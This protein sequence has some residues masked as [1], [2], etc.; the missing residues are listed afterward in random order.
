MVIKVGGSTGGLDI[1][2][3]ILHKMFGLSIPVMLYVGDTVLLLLQSFYSSSEQVLYGIL[4]VLLTSLVMNKVL[5]MGQNQTQVMIISPKFE[6]IN[7]AI[8]SKIDRGSTLIH[9]TTG[10]K[11]QDQKVVLTVISNRQL[12]ALNDLVLSIDSR[13]FIVANEVNEVKGRGFSLGKHEK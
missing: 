9:A 11:K 4:V 3:I 1:P 2:P 8:H 13:A 7:E 6:E 5:I 12:S 10:L